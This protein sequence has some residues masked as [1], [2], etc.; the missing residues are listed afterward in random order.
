MKTRR[1]KQAYTN[2]RSV[3]W[4]HDEAAW[5]ARMIAA[6]EVGPRP[7]VPAETPRQVAE[8]YTKNWHDRAF[9]ALATNAELAAA[10]SGADEAANYAAMTALRGAIGAGNRGAA[11]IPT[12]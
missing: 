6:G 10:M 8:R 12:S 5:R 9:V 7:T 2:L 1:E 11:G 3:G 4:S